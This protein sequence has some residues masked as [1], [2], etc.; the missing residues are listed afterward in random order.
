M[1]LIGS[2]VLRMLPFLLCAAPVYALVRFLL[3][4][5]HRRLGNRTTL[6][7]ET[8]LFVL[9]LFLTGLYSQAVVPALR[10]DSSGISVPGFLQGRVNL[11]PFTVF[12]DTWREV[13]EGNTAY[14]LIN[15][16]GN[17]GMFVPVGF[18]VPLLWREQGLGRTALVGFLYSLV[19]ELCQLLLPRGTDVDD[20][21]LNTLGAALGYGLFWICGRLWP[22]LVARFRMRHRA[23][24]ALE[25]ELDTK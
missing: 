7:H 11:I 22:A 17:I 16:L 10:I 21:W 2:Y 25:N 12:A 8:G 6:W 24:E 15:F 19:I 13:A 4:R 20:L 9:A 23:G 5:R 14:F 3:L 18:F 1:Q